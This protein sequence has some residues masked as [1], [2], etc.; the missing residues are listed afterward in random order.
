MIQLL[1][2]IFATS[3][4]KITKANFQATLFLLLLAGQVGNL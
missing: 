2:Q 1:R 4:T 3:V